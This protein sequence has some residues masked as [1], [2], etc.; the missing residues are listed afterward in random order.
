MSILFITIYVIWLVT[1]ILLN[2]L[3]HSKS[4]DRQ[5]A[6]KNSLPLIWA[7]I[8]ATI[9]IAVFISMKFYLP[10]FFNSAFEYAGLALIV[11]GILLRLIAVVSLGRFFTVD[12]TIRQ[13]HKLK[14]DGVYKYVRH[15]SYSASLLSFIGFGISLNSWLSL[16]ITT[17]AILT[18]FIFRMK[19][20]EKILIEQF[21]AEYLEYKKTTSGI[22]PFI[23]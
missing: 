2:R 23:Y 7:T 18:V 19:I 12:V 17:V 14:K 5:H 15:P 10:V 22:I 11:I 9:A 13:G 21:G 3:L 4:T 6:D 20:E 1:E 16:L 8:I